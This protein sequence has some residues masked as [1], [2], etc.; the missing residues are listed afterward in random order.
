M[1]T[2]LL[3]VAEFKSR[4]YRHTSQGGSRMPAD[5]WESPLHFQG[6]A[7]DEELQSK[8]HKLFAAKM[9]KDFRD[10]DYNHNQRRFVSESYWYDPSQTLIQNH[11]VCA[12]G[13]LASEPSYEMWLSQRCDSIL[14]FLLVLV[15]PASSKNL[16][17]SE[18]WPHISD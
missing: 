2:S 3:G 16:P 14:W 1:I 13:R 7:W 18:S 5:T 11:Q 10:K 12:F 4:C 9:M 6:L 17:H 8:R 15:N